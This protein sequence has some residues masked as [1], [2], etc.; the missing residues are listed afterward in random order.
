MPTGRD[1]VRAQRRLNRDSI[2]FIARWCNGNTHDSDL[3]GGGPTNVNINNLW[4]EFHSGNYYSI[5][6]FCRKRNYSLPFVT[7]LLSEIP[8]FSKVFKGRSHNNAS[9]KEYINFFEE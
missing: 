7:R 9:R 2:L 1:L 6:D 5:R 8:L 3:F 4:N